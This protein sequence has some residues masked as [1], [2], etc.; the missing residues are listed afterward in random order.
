MIQAYRLYTLALA[1]KPAMGAMNRMRE[2][3][4]LT[5]GAGWRLAAAYAAAGRNN[6]ANELI[7]DLPKKVESYKELS[8]SYGSSQRDH[9]MILETLVMLDR[10]EEAKY[11]LDLISENMASDRWYS[12]QTTAYSLMAAAKFVGVAGDDRE[13]DFKLEV[14]GEKTIKVNSEVPFKRIDLPVEEIASHAVNVHNESD[15]MLFIRIH[16]EGIPIVDSSPDFEND[17]NMQIRYLDLQGKPINPNNLTQGTD[18]ML[19]VD[20]SHPGIKADYKEMALTQIFPSGW[21]IRNLR[22]EEGE[23]NLMKDTP[24][25]QDIRDDRVYMYFDLDRGERKTFRVI[26][27]AAYL[28]EFYMPPIYCEAMYDREISAKKGGG[29]VTVSRPQ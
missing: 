5:I 6:V 29:W 10:T 22:M 11:M 24:R 27:H 28:G 15:A 16:S 23:S 7:T 25:Y 14:E 12:T 4:D 1:G 18:F 26:L 3:S 20:L 8:Y 17:L 19:E 9:A 13:L 2:L 21:E